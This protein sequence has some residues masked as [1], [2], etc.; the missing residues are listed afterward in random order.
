[1][2]TAPF[3]LHDSVVTAPE[4]EKAEDTAITLRVLL[5]ATPG[6]LVG[7]ALGQVLQIISQGARRGHGPPGWDPRLT[8]GRPV[9]L[10][11]T[12]QC[13]QGFPAH[14]QAGPEQ[15]RTLLSGP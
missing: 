11:I 3:L 5:K 12:L 15:A 7:V 9:S 4:G 8:A 2:F 13:H 6:V 1:M 14:R 10:G